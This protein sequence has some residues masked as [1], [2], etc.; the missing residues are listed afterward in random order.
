[1]N[2]HFSI[3]HSSDIWVTKSKFTSLTA[4]I[5][6]T[7]HLH[8]MYFICSGHSPLSIHGMVGTGAGDGVVQAPSSV[9]P[10]SDMVHSPG[11]VHATGTVDAAGMVRFPGKVSIPGTVAPG[12]CQ[13]L[14]RKRS[15]DEQPAVIPPPVKKSMLQEQAMQ[16]M[17]GPS[18][19]PTI[20][21]SNV[22]VN[23]SV[24]SSV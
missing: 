20:P 10:R 6:F 17:P 5:I 14:T 4:L 7:L 13:Q 11:A 18:A 21:S 12:P 9:G 22:R 16:H 24:F 15:N 3:N 2:C 1:M 23:V 8:F 19:G